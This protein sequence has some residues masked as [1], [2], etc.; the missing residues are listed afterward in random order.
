MIW[1]FSIMFLTNIGK[2]CDMELI[3]HWLYRTKLS[4]ITTEKCDKNIIL[5]ES[6]IWIPDHM[7]LIWYPWADQT[8]V[9]WDPCQGRM[10]YGIYHILFIFT[11]FTYSKLGNAIQNVINTIT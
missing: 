4:A 3:S 5:H 6:L 2:K 8:S 1:E 9:I 7:S 11:L 10:W